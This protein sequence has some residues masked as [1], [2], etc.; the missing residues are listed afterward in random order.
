MTKWLL[1][2]LLLGLTS[3][4]STAAPLQVCALHPLLADVARQ[5]GGER[6][7]IVDLVGEGGNLHRFEPRPADLA[8]MQASALVL[9]A[10]KNLESYLGRIQ[11]T[12]KN[13]TVLEVGRTIPSLTTGKDG[14]ATC[15]PQHAA[16]AADPHWWH[17]VENMR[18]AARVVALAMAEQD[19]A[20]KD[21]YLHNAGVYS[22]RLEHLQRWARSELGKVPLGQRKLVTAHNAFAY[23]AR[24]FGFEVIAV[25]GLN[26]EQNNTPQDLAKTIESV[27]NAGVKAIFPEINANTKI[28]QSI[29]AATGA[30]LG[31]PLISDGNGSGQDAGFEAMIRH[32]VASITLALGTP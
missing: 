2:G 19:P 31:S 12:L 16:G 6:V 14:V 23:F 1:T 17:G 24:E 10:G 4:L 29:A 22:Q 32:N 3:A 9:A 7:R 8:K 15:C 30:T 13:V 18:R 11:D 26:H 28:L 20:G 21:I 5:V 27:R 25:A